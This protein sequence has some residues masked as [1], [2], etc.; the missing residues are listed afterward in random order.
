[1]CKPNP[2]CRS[3]IK[4]QV[5]Q[6]QTN[7]SFE[8]QQVAVR[9]DVLRSRSVTLG[10]VTTMSVRASIGKGKG[11]GKGRLQ[12]CHWVLSVS[13]R[14]VCTEIGQSSTSVKTFRVTAS[15]STR[16]QPGSEE[17]NSCQAA[18]SQRPCNALP[19][20]KV[21]LFS[22]ADWSLLHFQ[23]NHRR[24]TLEGDTVQHHKRC[25]ISNFQLEGNKIYEG[26]KLTCEG[27]MQG[28]SLNVAVVPVLVV[29][30]LVL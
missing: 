23:H 2:L 27:L 15:H 22:S 12:P 21:R 25:K 1:M 9:S 13:E 3:A 8:Q 26:N 30:V 20:G 16:Q 4:L 28:Q 5:R 14:S 6:Q 11:K 17:L 18:G 10:Q 29:P 24:T 7:S 19:F